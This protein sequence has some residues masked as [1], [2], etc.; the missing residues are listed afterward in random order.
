MKKYIDGMVEPSDFV[1]YTNYFMQ[2]KNKT[3]NVDTTK[4]VFADLSDEQIATSFLLSTPPDRRKQ[5]TDEIEF[6][7]LFETANWI[8]VNSKQGCSKC[9]PFL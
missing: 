9:A 6:G 4:I 2:V 5:L 7:V 8:A 3:N 1:S